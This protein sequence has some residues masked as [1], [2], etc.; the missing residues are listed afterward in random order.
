MPSKN[1]LASKESVAAT[2]SATH[3]AAVVTVTA[4]VD[5]PVTTTYITG[6]LLSASSAIA[7]PVAATLT[8]VQGG[9]LTIQMPDTKVGPVS[10]IFGVHP[11]RI[12][13]GVDAVLT[14]PD[15]GASIVGTATLLYYYGAI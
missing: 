12:T 8:G 3:A 5:S 11:L 7:A 13:P 2:T 1:E 15:L 4:K 9:T 14:L 10:L 6:I